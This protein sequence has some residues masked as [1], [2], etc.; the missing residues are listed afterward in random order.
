MSGTGHA[1]E[2][3]SALEI[4]I[5]DSLLD[6]LFLLNVSVYLV[7]VSRLLP[8]PQSLVEFLVLRHVVLSPLNSTHF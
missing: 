3:S 7:E 2:V 6:L 1:V 5:K 4:G 8:R